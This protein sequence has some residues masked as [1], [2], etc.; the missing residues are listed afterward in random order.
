[1]EKSSKFIALQ[2]G[3]SFVLAYI[4]SKKKKSFNVHFVH[5]V[6]NWSQFPGANDTLLCYDSQRKTAERKRTVKGRDNSNMK[7]DPFVLSGQRSWKSGAAPGRTAD[8][9]PA[10]CPFKPDGTSRGS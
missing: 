10:V 4:S 1:M 3:Q 5:L 6:A 8:E 7:T 9:S 2:N